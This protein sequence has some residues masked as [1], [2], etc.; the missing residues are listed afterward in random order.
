VTG[1]ARGRLAIS[2]PRISHFHQGRERGVRSSFGQPR[3]VGLVS[4]QAE[5]LRA[6]AS[7]ARVCKDFMPPR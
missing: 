1:L 4:P 6:A 3:I 2:D 5:R 7:S